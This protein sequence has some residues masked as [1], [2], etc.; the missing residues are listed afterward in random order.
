MPNLEN[1]RRLMILNGLTGRGENRAAS[2]E[3]I[4]IFD[5]LLVPDAVLYKEKP[6]DPVH[7]GGACSSCK[8]GCS[9]GCPQG[10]VTVCNGT[11]CTNGC[12][13]GSSI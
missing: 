11:G 12:I 9:G 5:D 10:C 6:A 7:E 8:L 4:P 1:L 3:I 2:L 13:N